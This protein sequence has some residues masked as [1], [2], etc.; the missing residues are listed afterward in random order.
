MLEWMQWVVCRSVVQWPTIAQ[1]IFSNSRPE[2][3]SSRVELQVR[4]GVMSASGPPLETD[5]LEGLALRLRHGTLHS[6]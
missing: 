1:W 4:V 6:H 3:R 5:T 2:V